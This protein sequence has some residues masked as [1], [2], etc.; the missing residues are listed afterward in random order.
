MQGPQSRASRR[1][2]RSEDGKEE[3]TCREKVADYLRWGA[4]GREPQGQ[5]TSPDGSSFVRE[6]GSNAN[7]GQHYPH[8][9]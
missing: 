5:V 8:S 6:N 3:G 2:T 1:Q 7:D 4:A 9:H